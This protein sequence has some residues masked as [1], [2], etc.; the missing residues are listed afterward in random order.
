MFVPF[1]VVRVLQ[2]FSKKYKIYFVNI[3]FEK[4]ALWDGRFFTLSCTE[5]TQIFDIRRRKNLSPYR[6]LGTR[7][8]SNSKCHLVWCPRKSTAQ[9]EF[10]EKRNKR[11]Y[12]HSVQL[13]RS[14][15]HSNGAIDFLAEG[16]P[17]KVA[18]W[19]RNF[20]FKSTVWTLWVFPPHLQ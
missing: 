7:Q 19:V 17:Y 5:L 15:T 3:R 11:H 10:V 4:I 9:F 16:G 18:I 12:E 8:V 20:Y 6:R 13:L 14:F 1:C 2:W